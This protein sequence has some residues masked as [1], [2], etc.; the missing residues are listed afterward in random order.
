MSGTERTP[1]LGVATSAVN[2]KVRLD[3]TGHNFAN[4]SDAT[5]EILLAEEGYEATVAFARSQV[6]E[7]PCYALLDGGEGVAG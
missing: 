5:G 3:L 4:G 6:Q 2:T 7:M 1:T